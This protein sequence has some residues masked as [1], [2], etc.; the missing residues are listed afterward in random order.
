MNCLAVSFKGGG[1]E[2][3]KPAL[4]PTYKPIFFLLPVLSGPSSNNYE[5]IIN[6]LTSRMSPFEPLTVSSPPPPEN[7]TLIK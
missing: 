4:M 2:I 3:Y 7:L 5:K 1:G 6:I